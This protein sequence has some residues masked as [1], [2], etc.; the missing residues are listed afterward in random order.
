MLVTKKS[1]KYKIHRLYIYTDVVP[2]RR[3][4]MY[5]HRHARPSS[6]SSVRSNDSNLYTECDMDDDTDIDIEEKYEAKAVGYEVT[7]D[8]LMY[9]L[10]DHTD[11]GDIKDMSAYMRRVY[12]AHGIK[13]TPTV[14]QKP[15][16][17][18][19]IPGAKLVVLN[20]IVVPEEEDKEDD[21]KSSIQDKFKGKRKWKQVLTDATAHFRAKR[22]A[23]AKA[24]RLST[25][26]ELST[27]RMRDVDA[28]EGDK[29]LADVRRMLE[30]WPVQ[31]VTYQKTFHDLIIRSCL[32]KIYG[33]DCWETESLRVLQEHDMDKVDLEVLISTQRRMGKTWSIAMVVCALLMCV[34]GIR[35][36]VISTGGRAS[37]SLTET[38]LSFIERVPGGKGRIVRNNKEQLFISPE[39]TEHLNGQQKL[40]QCNLTTTS[41]LLS[42]P[43]NSTGLRAYTH[44][45]AHIH[46]HSLSL[47]VLYTRVHVYVCIR[48]S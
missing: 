12:K 18:S 20:D 33:A 48:V 3:T 25:R 15:I 4:N 30:S 29:R 17:P 7:D 13:G 38:V 40:E 19:K 32:P 44:L 5:R 11:Y 43:S 39:G 37:G 45:H 24:R 27:D 31:R 16:G 1:C 10:D 14:L 28:G 46:T 9:N 21:I 47:C 22:M 2:T 41:K 26:D 34:P 36:I 23:Y 35:I 8:G 6:R 42:F